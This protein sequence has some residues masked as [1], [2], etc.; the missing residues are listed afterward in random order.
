MLN[1]CAESE[2]FS[3]TGEEAVL[4]LHAEGKVDPQVIGKGRVGLQLL[5][6]GIDDTGVGLVH[7]LLR[8]DLAAQVLYLLNRKALLTN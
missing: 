8:L 2:L 1:F 5:L 7:C 6:G 4:V 3:A